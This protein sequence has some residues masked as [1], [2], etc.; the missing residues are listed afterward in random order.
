[1]FSGVAIHALFIYFIYLIYLLRHTYDFI[2]KI[3]FHLATRYIEN[4]QQLRSTW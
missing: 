3:V 4:A 1:M 2:L